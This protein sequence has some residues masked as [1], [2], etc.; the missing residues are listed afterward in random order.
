LVRFLQLLVVCTLAA[1][2]G[3]GSDFAERLYK[4]GQRAERAGDVLHAYLL[5]AR[6]AALDPK[7]LFYA[8]RRS[9]LQAIAEVTAD[10]RL[11]PEPV[12]EEEANAEPAPAAMARPSRA[13]MPV[14]VITTAMTT[15][16]QMPTLVEMHC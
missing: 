4:A 1:A 3:G 15:M 8:S 6:A 11:D 7:N 5:Y 16:V 10:Q 14:S 9:A 12:A 13:V 2:V